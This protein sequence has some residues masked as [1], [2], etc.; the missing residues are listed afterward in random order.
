MSNKLFYPICLALVLAL[1]GFAQAELLVNGDFEAGTDSWKTW[2]SGSGSGAGGW[3]WSSAYGATV[4]EDGTAQS[5]NNYIEVGFWPPDGPWWGYCYAF[6][7]HPATEGKTYQMSAWLRDGNADGAPSLIAGGGTIVWEW[8]VTA[9]VGGPDTGDRGDLVDIDG[10]GVGGNS[11]KIHYSFDLTEE[12]TYFSTVEV[13]PPGT[14]GLSVIFGTPTS[15][16]NVDIDAASFVELVTIPV[17]NAG[18]EDPVLAEDGW[19]WLDVPGWTQVGGEGP[20]IWNVTINDFDP[21]VAPE[22]QNV[23]YTEN[24]VGDAGGVTQVLTE[25]FAANTNYTLTVD[26]GNSWSYYWSGYS[27][28]LLAGGIV[29]AEDNDTLWPE[30]MKWATSTVVYTYDPADSSLVGQP[31]EIRL[32]NLG[33]DKDNPPVDRVVGVEFDNVTLSY[34]AA[35]AAPNVQIENWEAAVALASP[36]FLATNVENGTYDIGAFSGDMTYEFVVNCNPDE[37]E[38]SLAL[39]GRV[40]FGDT[41]AGLKYEQWENTGTYGATVFGVADHDYGVAT[42]PGLDTHL[43]FV[44]SGEETA[45]Y[46]NGAYRG[47]IG[48]EISLSGIVGIGRAIREDGT[49]VDNFDGS[50][51]GVAIYDTALSADQ[52]QAHSDAYFMP[53][54]DV[55]APGDTVQG[56]PDDGDWP[57]GEP[58]LMIIDNDSETKFLHFGG[59]FDPNEGPSGFRVTASA[60]QSIVT[61]LTFTTAN[62]APERDPVAFELS[63]SNESIDGPYTL[64]A[65]GDIVDFNEPNNEWPRFTKNETPISFDNEVIY[66]HYQVLF[67]AIRDA[68]SANSMQIAEV[69]LLGIIFVNYNATPADGAI[70]VP[71]T[72]SWTPGENAVSHDVYFGTSSPP[73]FIGNQAETSYDPGILEY[74]TTYYWQ[75]DAVEADGTA[76]A[77]RILSFKTPQTA[78]TGTILREVWE[79]IGG[80]SV[81]DLTSNV[82]YPTNPSYSDE[83]TLFETPTNFADNFGSRVHGYLHPETSG[84]YLFWIATDD[85]SELW[86]STD[87]SPANAVIISTTSGWAGSRDFDSGNVTPSG[88]ISLVGGQKYYVSGIYKE[89]GGGDNLAVAW[90]GPD[91]PT[92]AVIDGYYLSPF[93]NLWAWAP[94]PADGAEDVLIGTTLSWMP[95]VTAATHDVYFG[96]SSP[97]AFI[98]NQEATTYYPGSIEVGT[99]YYWQIDTVEADGTTTAGDIWSFTTGFSNVAVDIRIATGDDD[100]EERLREDRN[101]DLDT[102]SSDLE[103]PYEDFPID[104][105]QRVG[106]RFVDVGVPQ[107]AQIVSSY[108][109]FEVDEIKDDANSVVNV[110]IDGQLTPDAEPFVDEFMNVSQRP[111]WTST[112]VPWSVPYWIAENDKSQTP[113][114]SVLVQELVNQADWAGGNAMVFTIQDDPANPST[115]VRAAES[116]NGESSNAPLLHIKAI[117]EAATGPSPADGAENVPII[118]T[119]VSWWPGFG[120]VSHDGYMGVSSPP[121]FIGNTPEVTFDPGVL[122]ASTTYYWQVDAV[123]ADGTKHPGQIWSFTTEPG[124]ASQPDPADMAA[125]MALDT[126]LSWSPGVTAATHDVYFGTSS[127]PA[128]IGNQTDPNFDPGPLE[129]DTTYYWQVD[130]VEA[131][132]TTKYTGDIWSFS[133]LLDIPITDPSLLGWWTFDGVLGSVA[134]DYSGHN[135][136]GTFVGDI[137]FETDDIM[138]PVLSLPGGSNQFVKVGEVGISGTDERTIACWAKADNTDIPDWTLIFGFTGNEDGSGGTGSHFNIGSLGGPGGV[139]A[140]VWGWEETIF[141]DE[142]ALDWHHYAMTYDGTTIQYYGDGAL[143]DTDPG[144]S[145]VIDLTHADNVHIGSRITQDSSFPGKVDDARIYNIVLSE[146]ELRVIAGLLEAWSPDPADGATDVPKILTL[147]WSPGPTAISHDVYFSADQQAV[148]DGTALIGNQAE[149]SYTPTGLAKSTTY[150]WRVDEVEADGTTKHTGDVWSFTVTSL[151]R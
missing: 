97:P 83:V 26:V 55:T 43:V 145:N 52:I 103:F 54:P 51:F 19:T 74:G 143:M 86:L 141:S 58:P 66:A 72:L 33:L 109:E 120:A 149:T 96:T 150:Y 59:N 36:G 70:V 115:G 134:V 38:V 64:I 124:E 133:T 117:V 89:G 78:T 3:W 146:A 11:D 135:R 77:G 39:I 49:F 130:E 128:F 108:I 90:E 85:S 106:M 107:G 61:G 75:V 122:A 138:G 14:N 93:V 118:G 102:G 47:S 2:G 35:A 1:A 91:S 125:G 20:G 60:S 140:H 98:G 22:G 71:D 94:S 6:Q 76:R 41:R 112:V 139:G 127:P 34:A 79:G 21:V 119:I 126:T 30:Y 123:D 144:K 28:Q 111:A 114:I 15:Y 18:F 29:I 16:V 4:I 13:A 113:D 67:T 25:T 121:T 129:F 63:G 116:Y 84:D 132:G 68:A 147:S 131:D 148:I 81:S 31:L 57:D 87:E 8:R 110:I 99:T 10:D 69:E 82:N 9:P 65:S 105:L 46:V 24:A 88:P 37:Q 104:D 17:P 42:K 80:G 50:I 45:L 7:E 56:V 27:V 32:L 92:R 44:S 95:A 142:E 53:L 48:A 62:D 100:V 73:A 137:S 5:G 101:G 151:G 136:Y 12:W 40:N 23:L